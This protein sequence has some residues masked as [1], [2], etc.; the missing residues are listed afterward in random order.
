MIDIKN[1]NIK[2]FLKTTFNKNIESITNEELSTLTRMNFLNDKD[3]LHD[4]KIL[5]F[6]PNV[7]EIIVEEY[8]LQQTDIDLIFSRNLEEVTFI[9]CNLENINFPMN[10]LKNLSLLKCSVADYNELL[11]N[12]NSLITIDIKMPKDEQ[13]LDCSYLPS[14][15]EKAIFDYCILKNISNLMNLDKLEY[16]SVIGVHFT[17]KDL[18]FLKHLPLKRLFINEEYENNIYIQNL[19]R[20]SNCE[21]EHDHRSL[22]F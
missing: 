2:M 11:K 18:N 21:I 14:S 20:E 9:K 17:D 6:L 1:N 15:L 16:L 12:M 8:D 7:K 13:D 19:K 10:S 5:E 4:F 3:S 22:L